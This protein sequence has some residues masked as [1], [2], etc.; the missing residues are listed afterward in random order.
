MLL[1]I[2]V[3][4]GFII[5]FILYSNIVNYINRGHNNKTQQQKKQMF[6]YLQQL[7]EQLQNSQPQLQQQLKL[8]LFWGLLFIFVYIYIKDE[9]ALYKTENSNVYQIK[10]KI[11]NTT[12]TPPANANAYADDLPHETYF[13]S[14]FSKS[15][16]SFI[17]YIHNLWTF[18]FSVWGQT[19]ENI[20]WLTN[21]VYLTIQEMLKH[22]YHWML[23]TII[24][25]LWLI[26]KN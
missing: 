11:E 3:L 20:L 7:Q 4:L 16:S 10:K 26:W 21:F 18:L 2:G 23:E 25:I 17:L 14:L 9:Q 13:P 24:Y 8:V 19:T 22:F 12:T 5:M 1:C 15:L 6:N